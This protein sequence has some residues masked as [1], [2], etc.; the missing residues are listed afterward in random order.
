[1]RLRTFIL[2]ILIFLVLAIGAFVVYF[3]VVGGGFGSILGGGS[4]GDNANG[5]PSVGVPEEPGLPPPSPTPSF[6]NVVVAR[7]PIPIGEILTEE[8]L[9]T[10]SRPVTNVALQG[11]Y[12]FTSTESLV[13]TIAIVP[14]A[15]GQEIL[16]PMVANN[17]TDVTAMGSDLSLY[18]PEGNI[19]IAF[20]VDRYSGASLAMRPGDKVDVIM[21]LRTVEIDS[22]FNSSLPNLTA[23]VSQSRLEEGSGEFLF[24]PTFEGR[25][26][27][28]PELNQVASIIPGTNPAFSVPGQFY[29]PGVVIPKRVT[30]LTIQRANVIYVG[31][32][33]DPR[34]LEAEQAAAQVQAES[35]VALNEQG[36]P[37]PVPTPTP[38]PERQDNPDVIILSMPVQDALALK[39]AQDRDVKLDLVLRSAGDVTPFV[40]TSVSLPQIVDQGGLAL[41]E[42]SDFDLFNPLYDPREPLEFDALGIGDGIGD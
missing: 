15:R 5:S 7:I 29:E 32:W 1:M 35:N 9:V 24:P 17:P 37:I 10:E 36:T 40:T 28:I 4:D 11:N 6:D 14:I 12:T 39:F 33:R 18:I 23:R 41:P 20:P 21:T 3:G 42:P 34:V 27:F 8:L 30:Q 2:I 22:Q 25:L 19:A 38:I 13:G 31:E 16:Q 26:E